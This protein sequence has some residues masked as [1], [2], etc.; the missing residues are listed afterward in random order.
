M[1]FFQEKNSTF[2]FKTVGVIIHQGKILLHHAE[3]SPYWS[4]PGGKVEL[5]ETTK[6]AVVRE[7]WEETQTKSKVVRLIY[8]VENFF[9]F[10]KEK[11]HEINFFYLL[12]LPKNAKILK[13]KQFESWEGKEK[14]IFVWHDLDQLNKIKLYPKFLRSKLKKLPKTFEHIIWQDR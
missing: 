8:V 1:V 2:I 9:D 10:Q 4:I 12:R 7:I 13:Q 6:E 3:N 11:V 5:Q 14:L